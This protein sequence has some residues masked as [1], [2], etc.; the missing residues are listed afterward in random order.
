M[1]MT[2]SVKTPTSPLLSQNSNSGW[3]ST[4]KRGR[5]DSDIEQASRLARQRRKEEL[6]AASPASTSSSAAAAASN[7]GKRRTGKRH[8]YSSDRG[9]QDGTSGQK[10]RRSISI[11]D[12]VEDDD[13]RK[14]TNFRGRR[15]LD[16]VRK[17]KNNI[18]NNNSSKNKRHL[19]IYS[20]NLSRHRP[21]RHHH[22]HHQQQEDPIGCNRTKI[23]PKVLFSKEYSCSTS[24]KRRCVS[25]SSRALLDHEDKH[26][27]KKKRQ[28]D[29]DGII[30]YSDDCNNIIP[31][32]KES[33][34]KLERC[35]V[36]LKDPPSNYCRRS[37]DD[38]DDDDRVH[39][40]DDITANL[41][42]TQQQA[43]RT[44]TDLQPVKSSG[45][46]NDFQNELK[47]VDH[48]PQHHDSV[49]SQS[50]KSKGISHLPDYYDELPGTQDFDE[51]CETTAT[52]HHCNFKKGAKDSTRM[53]HNHDQH[54]NNILIENKDDFQDDDKN[55]EPSNAS[56]SHVEDELDEAGTMDQ[57]YLSLPRGNPSFDESESESDIGTSEEKEVET[58]YGS[59]PVTQEQRSPILCGQLS[60]DEGVLSQKITTW[61]GQHHSQNSDHNNPDDE[62][63]P[64]CTH[65]NVEEKSGLAPLTNL[66]FWE[67]LVEDQTKERQQSYKSKGSIGNRKFQSAIAKLV[68]AKNRK[69]K[70]K[71]LD[72][73]RLLW[74]P[75]ILDGG[76]LTGGIV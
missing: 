53:A 57:T 5:D 56:K 41:F 42:E 38:D 15:I 22:H 13:E 6:A 54:E 19:Q 27:T 40:I 47:V 37:D 31:S 28:N 2:T 36:G 46:L 44:S 71:R 17:K 23:H 52:I 74:L 8:K 20:P 25:K 14:Q 65:N 73:N 33:S 49:D 45:S 59:V 34:T 18:D 10:N 68:V 30:H 62:V 3:M 7:T 12:K 72:K 26:E 66:R 21:R 11:I 70:K 9:F 76:G 64:R 51:S 35:F 50:S 61:W 69:A 67:N 1:T 4:R 63:G 43:D 16:S 55:T 58:T 60:Y 29:D 75:S 48:H 24:A 39:D 32:I